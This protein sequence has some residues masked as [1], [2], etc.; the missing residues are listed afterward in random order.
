M[1]TGVT[2]QA[3]VQRYLHER[4]QLGFA[5]KSEEA[6]LMRFARFADARG[7]RGALTQALQL[8]W[9]QEHVQRTGPETAARRLE[10]L[11]PFSAFYRQFEVDTEVLASSFLGRR[12]H[13]PVPHIYTAQEIRDLL[14]QA[15]RL[16]PVGSLRPLTYQTLFGLLVVAGLRLSEALKL[17]VGDVDLHRQTITVRETKFHKSR[18]LPVQNSVVQ[19]LTDYRQVRDRHAE[20]SNGAPF[21]VSHT[22]GILPVPTVEYVFRCLRSQLGWHARG[23]YAAPRIQDMRHTMAV[24]RL[25][26]WHEMGVSIDHAMFWLCTYLGHASISNTYWYLTGVPDLMNLIGL[27]FERFALQGEC[28]E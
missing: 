24:R 16:P 28:D 11:R 13:R 5:L 14:D 19:A 6:V 27:K 1:S 10:A 4:R 12:R 7:H 21:F 15:S 25:Q 18:C 22:G 20:H 2:I 17:L 9:A 26:L 8:E 3:A 23:D